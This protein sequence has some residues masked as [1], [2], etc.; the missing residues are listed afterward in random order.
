MVSALVPG[1]SS[2]CLSPRQ[3]HCVVCWSKT[4]N[5]HSSSLHPGVKMG[6]SDLML[7]V[8]LGNPIQGGVEIPSYF[9]VQEL[10]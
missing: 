6:T 7:R 10:G 3:G 5:S 9:M 4:L 8:T 1:S 2:P